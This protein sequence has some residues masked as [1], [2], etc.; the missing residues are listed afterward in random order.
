MELDNNLSEEYKKGIKYNFSPS[1]VNTGK[2][3]S[4]ASGRVSASKDISKNTNIQGYADLVASK[5]GDQDASLK[6]QKV[7]VNI[8]HNFAKGGVVVNKGIGA[9]TKPHNVFGSKGKK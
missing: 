7:G 4:I 6:A 9:S 8:T 2:D 3:F 1:F 5:F